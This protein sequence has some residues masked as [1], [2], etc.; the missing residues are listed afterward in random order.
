MWPADRRAPLGAQH[1][2]PTLDGVRVWWCL[3]ARLGAEQRIG[4][5]ITRLLLGVQEVPS[6]NLGGPTNGF[7]YLHL[8]DPFVTPFWSPNG[9]QTGRQPEIGRLIRGS[10]RGSFQHQIHHSIRSSSLLL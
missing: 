4:Q 6:S 5:S 3:L 10:C 9:V 7:K 8:A 2:G 1:V